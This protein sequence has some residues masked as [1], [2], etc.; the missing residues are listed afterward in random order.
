[1]QAVDALRARAE[2]WWAVA[3]SP[4]ITQAR[5]FHI[6]HKLKSFPVTPL[7]PAAF[8][9]PPAYVQAYS[10]LFEPCKNVLMG[11]GTALRSKG[12]PVAWFCDAAGGEHPAARAAEGG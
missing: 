5:E 10:C 3:L 1:M 4:L 9:P 12:H 7:P 6:L 8:C 11:I 2:G